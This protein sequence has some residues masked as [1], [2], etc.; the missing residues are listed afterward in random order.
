[1]TVPTSIDPARLLSEHL[2]RAEPDLLRGL[3]KT[4][5]EALMG[6]EADALCGAPYGARSPERVNSRNCYRPREWDTRT[7]TVELAIPKL[8]LHGASW[9]RSS[10]NLAGGGTV[11]LVHL[12]R[13][14]RI[15]AA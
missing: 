1:M 3:L 8:T 12:R 14:E 10:V 13:R 2:E 15:L 11:P 4:F 9:Q 5:V 7:G 6:A